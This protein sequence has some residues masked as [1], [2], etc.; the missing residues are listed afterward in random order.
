MKKNY[1][2]TIHQIIITG[3]WI[4]DE[5]GKALK[6]FGITEPQY[7]VLRILSR[8]NGQPITVGKISDGMIQ[9]SSNVT[10]IID[11]LLFKGLVYRQECPTHRRKMDI[12]MSMRRKSTFDQ[13]G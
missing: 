13:I 9:R 7:N 2:Q 8:A 4:T 3:H 1:F 6:E 5:V 11:K 12:T 10:R